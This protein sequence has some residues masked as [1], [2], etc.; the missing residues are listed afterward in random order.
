MRMNDRQLYGLFA[1]PRH[2]DGSPKLENPFDDH[3]LTPEGVFK[4]HL[5]LNGITDRAK[6]EE[7]WK[8]ERARRIRKAGEAFDGGP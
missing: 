6:Q 8:V 2:A 5:W 4:R 7:L 3:G 1:I